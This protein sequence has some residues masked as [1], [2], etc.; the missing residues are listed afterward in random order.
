MLQD[1]DLVTGDL[2]ENSDSETGSRE[3]VSTNKVGWDIKQSTK[4][5]DLVFDGVRNG[6]SYAQILLLTLEEFPQWLYQ[7]QLHILQQS[8]D[9]V[10][11]LDGGTWA[12]EADTLDDIRVQRSL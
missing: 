5:S 10:V 3:G 4:S 7:L 12:L 9:I 11:G 1:G 8:T 6:P 2:T